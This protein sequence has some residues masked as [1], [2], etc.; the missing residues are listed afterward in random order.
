MGWPVN[1]K[2]VRVSSGST[3]SGSLVASKAAAV[4]LYD[5][6]VD[7]LVSITGTTGSTALVNSTVD[8]SVLLVANATPGVEPIVADSSVRGLLLC[9]ANSPAPINLGAANNVRGL[10]LGECSTL[11]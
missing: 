8:G 11:D 5:T 4:H 3:V 6:T 9:V 2:S 1:Q 10:A 7:D